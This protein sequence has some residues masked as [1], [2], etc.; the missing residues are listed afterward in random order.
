[1]RR[2]LALAST[3]TAALVAASIVA[4]LMDPFGAPP[5]TASDAVP[6][7]WGLAALIVLSLTFAWAPTLAWCA[8]IVGGSA[9]AMGAVALAR[10]V[11][12]AVA[13]SGSGGSLEPAFEAFVAVC[14]LVPLVVAAGY[15]T[16][17]GRRRVVVVG[18]WGAIV[19]MA[20]VFGLNWARRAMGGDPGGVSQGMWLAVIGILGTIGLVRDLRPAFAATRARITASGARPGGTGALSV[21]RIFIDELV[22]GREAGR[23]EAVETERGRLAADLHAGLLPSLRNALTV[24]EGGGTIER[25]AADLRTAVDEVESLLVARRSVVLEEIG[26]LAGIEWLAERVEERSAVRVAIEVLADGDGARP[27]REVERAAFRIAQL[28]LDNVVRHAPGSAARVVVE[29]RRSAVRL[30]IADDGAGPPVDEAAAA[31]AG[32]RGVADM[33]AEAGACGGSLWVGGGPGGRGVV[34]RFGWPA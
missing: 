20:T 29:V 13:A 30:Q 31:R 6:H 15:A 28:A 27:P 16:A 17:D 19:V 25:L 34:V 23:V 33:R 32:R 2:A 9:A 3:A 1:M 21:L 24:A 14:L 4:R 10:E 8:A 11:R 12:A 22:P 18:A 26:L 7:L 5:A